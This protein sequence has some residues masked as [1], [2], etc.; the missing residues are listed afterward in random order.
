MMRKQ[1]GLLSWFF[2]LVGAGI[3]GFLAA[4]LLGK[5]NDTW[6]YILWSGAL[7]LLIFCGGFLGV[8]LSLLVN[9]RYRMQ[10]GSKWLAAGLISGVAIFA[11]GCGGQALFLFAQTATGTSPAVMLLA[12][13]EQLSIYLFLIRLLTVMV[14]AVLFHIGY[15]GRITLAGAVSALLRG[16]AAAI[17]LSL[18]GGNP[19]LAALFICLLLGA[20]Y[21]MYEERSNVWGTPPHQKPAPMQDRNR[22]NEQ[23]SQRQNEV[24][25]TRMSKLSGVQRGNMARRTDKNGKKRRGILI[26]AAA[27]VAAIVLV[28]VGVRVLQRTAPRNILVHKDTKLTCPVTLTETNQALNNL[29]EQYDDEQVVSGVSSTKRLLLQFEGD[30]IDLSAFPAAEVIADEENYLI[31]QFQT[32]EE[33]QQCLEAVEGMDGVVC[34]SMDK[35]QSASQNAVAARTAYGTPYT[36][37]STGMVYYSWGVEYLGLDRMSSWVAGQQTEP[38]TVAVLDSGVEPCNETQGRILEGLDMFDP[39]GNGWNDM[40]GHGTHVAG[41]ILDCTRGLDVSV[42]P[43]RVLGE[44]GKGTDSSVIQG[45][46]AAIANDVDVINMSLGGRRDF[47]PQHD[48]KNAK[49]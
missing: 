47:S 39:S 23:Y 28:A 6:T 24:I 22:F 7:F 27:A 31:V 15:F 37:P 11:V 33:A 29:I 17:A 20:A 21:T 49:D 13:W 48:L 26:G 1:F 2:S 38:V 3:G 9:K 45:L 30:E 35:Y 36:S 41:T 44:N 14:C 32:E 18:T 43:V 46:K 42:F 5:C 40:A 10:Q 25:Q 34:A 4:L 16:L 19:Y 8:Q 12:G